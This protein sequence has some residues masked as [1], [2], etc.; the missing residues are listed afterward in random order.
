MRLTHL[1]SSTVRLP[2]LSQLL[3]GFCTTQLLDQALPLTGI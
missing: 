3:L 1:A 2:D